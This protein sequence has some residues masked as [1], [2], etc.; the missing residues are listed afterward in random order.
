MVVAGQIDQELDED[1][2]HLVG[3]QLA[4]VERPEELI[5]GPGAGADS[6]RADGGGAGARDRLDRWSRR[7]DPLDRLVGRR[8]ARLA[9]RFRGGGTGQGTAVAPA[10]DERRRRRAMTARAST[11]AQT[12]K[13]PPER[14]V[15]GP[16]AVPARTQRPDR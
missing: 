4:E 13:P 14:V 11:A 2:A 10:L 16:F 1:A 6:A 8:S 9:G 12:G 5:L 3:A 7:L 15:D